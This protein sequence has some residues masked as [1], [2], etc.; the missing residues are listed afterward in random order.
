M[1]LGWARLTSY[2]LGIRKPIY[3]L[4]FT[5]FIVFCDFIM[6]AEDPIVD[7]EAECN[8]PFVGNVL[9]FVLSKYPANTGYTLIKLFLVLIFGFIGC[10]FGRQIVH[11]KFLRDYCELGMFQEDNG[12]FA[13]M[14][15]F[16]AISL[17]IGSY[18]YNAIIEG[19]DDLRL[20]TGGLGYSQL[21]PLNIY[22]YIHV[23]ITNKTH[24]H[25]HKYIC[26]HSF[27]KQ[28]FFS[29]RVKPTLL[30]I[31]VT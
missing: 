31:R 19:Q 3:R 18:V 14:P 17:F 28:L 5:F 24:I 2:Q 7:S 11:H 22:T 4:F 30:M 6:F 29:R 8:I 27:Q 10:A 13:I 25:T 12:T 16:C 23:Y 20:I 9:T 15:V 21:S 1:C 26:F